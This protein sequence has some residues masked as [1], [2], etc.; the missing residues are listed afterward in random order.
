MSKAATSMT[1]SQSQAEVKRCTYQPRVGVHLVLSETGPLSIVRVLDKFL[2]DWTT[3]LRLMAWSR[4]QRSRNLP[5]VTL[6]EVHKVEVSVRRLCRRMLSSPLPAISRALLQ[7][8]WSLLMAAMTFPQLITEATS[9]KT[10]WSK[11]SSAY[12]LGGIHDLMHS[13]MFYRAESKTP[14]LMH[15]QSISFLNLLRCSNKSAPEV[16]ESS[17]P[18][19]ELGGP[20]SKRDPS[21]TT[22]HSG[23][24]A[25]RKKPRVSYKD[26]WVAASILDNVVEEDYHRSP[27]KKPRLSMSPKCVHKQ[28]KPR[29]LAEDIGQRTDNSGGA[30][31]AYHCDY[32]VA[33]PCKDVKQKCEGVED[34]SKLQIQQVHG[35]LPSLPGTSEVDVAKLVPVST[36]S[37]VLRTPLASINGRPDFS[38]KTKSRPWSYN[39]S[40]FSPGDEFWNEAIQVVDDLLAPTEGGNHGISLDHHHVERSGNRMLSPAR[41]T[42]T[43]S[44]A[45]GTE[46]KQSDAAG[47]G[48]GKTYFGEVKARC[49][50]FKLNPLDPMNPCNEAPQVTLD[51]QSP[52]PVRHFNFNSQ[53]SP[54]EER[55]APL[56]SSHR[57]YITLESRAQSDQNEAQ[58]N[59]AMC[60]LSTSEITERESVPRDVQDAKLQNEALLKPRFVEACSLPEQTDRC[61]DAEIISNKQHHSSRRA[62]GDVSDEVRSDVVSSESR[63]HVSE[64]SEPPDESK[65]QEQTP[66]VLTKPGSASLS[67]KPALD[68]T[69]WLPATVAAVYKRKGVTQLYPWQVLSEPFAN[70]KVVIGLNNSRALEFVV[71][72]VECLMLNGVLEGKNVVFSASTRSLFATLSIVVFHLLNLCTSYSDLTSN[73]IS[74]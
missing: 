13:E 63:T 58:I 40:M 17:L 73:Y 34:L 57:M 70:L 68:L 32:S 4:R 53:G 8:E 54:V 47:R 18:D 39:V 52:L 62:L 2:S 48:E 15:G 29:T 1:C 24:A 51:V 7:R 12:C 25:D 11:A 35:V 46:L 23:D 56:D 21:P 50:G 9:K 45:E 71:P 38:V 44:I 42:A 30:A 20:S 66:P 41:S 3:Y 31:I 65:V 61:L 28:L 5:S 19:G 10:A 49:A 16:T 74:T 33:N 67:S 37:D 64:V 36:A 22:L 55:K 69:D 6:E 59:G 72:Q 26:L 43:G 60:R 27:E 14:I